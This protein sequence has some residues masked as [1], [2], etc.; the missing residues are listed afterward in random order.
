MADR[1]I[2]DQ[3]FHVLLHERDQRPINNANDRESDNPGADFGVKKNVGKEW[4]RKTNKPVS[5]HLQQ[6]PSQDDRTRRRR[7]YVG[8][9]QPGME[10][11]HR[12]FDGESEEETQE[13]KSS[14]MRAVVG[15][16]PRRGFVQSRQAK[17]VDVGN[18]VMVEVKEQD[19]E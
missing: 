12:N 4:Q 15:I 13:K 10:G 14:D 17:S 7:F 3:F 11:E 1:R 19:A 9:G 6:N 8:V 18:Q 5:S 16:H 2:R